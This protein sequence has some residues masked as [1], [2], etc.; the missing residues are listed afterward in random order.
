MHRW[1]YFKCKCKRLKTKFSSVFNKNRMPPAHTSP[2]NVEAASKHQY[3]HHDETNEDSKLIQR[4]TTSKSELVD[5]TEIPLMDR[6]FPVK[7]VWRNVFL[8]VYLH[9]AAVYGGYLFIT[10]QVMWQTFLW[11]K[12]G[13]KPL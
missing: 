4:K 2:I 13:L 6:T 11:G 8:F 10:G 12:L 3:E 7:I 5:E 1:N 9:L